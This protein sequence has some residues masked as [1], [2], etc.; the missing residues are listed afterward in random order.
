MAILEP[1]KPPPPDYYAANLE[2]VVAGVAR[3]YNDLLHPDERAHAERILALSPCALRLFA[4]LLSRAGPTIRV[5]RLRYREIDDTNAALDELAAVGLIHRN[6]EVPA[7]RVVAELTIAELNAAFPYV[8]VPRAAH[9][10]E[11]VARI[12]ARYPDREIR[13]RLALVH[14]WVAIARPDIVE[15]LCVLFFGTDERDLTT[16]VLEDLGVWR[17]ET[18]TMDPSARPFATREELDRYRALGALRAAMPS[19]ASWDPAPANR[20][21]DVLWQRDAHRST[22]RRRRRLLDRLGYVA[23]R[24]SDADIALAC[25]KRSGTPFA[26]QRRVRTLLR[27]G[28][29]CGARALLAHIRANPRSRSEREFARRF[30]PTR[31]RLSAHRFAPRIE[32]LTLPSAPP[33]NVER[34]TL[35]ALLERPGLGAHLENR[36]PLALF[37]LA[38]WD[39][40]FAPVPGAFSNA[41]QLGP[42]DLLWS[43]FAAARRAVI[44]ARLDEIR[45]AEALRSRVLG[46]WREKCG[47]S[48]ALVSWELLDPN[49]IGRALDRV[50]V[51]AWRKILAHLANNLAEARTGFPDLVVFYDD[52]AYD[53]VEVKGPGDALRSDQRDWLGLLDS[54]GIAARVLKVSW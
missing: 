36:F 18:Y 38:F 47:V 14:P 15:G 34:A 23:E 21:L 50:P 32:T 52:G 4:R 22:E 29:V 11:L 35:G 24:S 30:E 43:D 31:C 10:A 42:L 20:L 16:F 6:F 5:D 54:V 46:T 51:A 45:S 26:R 2:R 19:R 39:I 28:D 44:D 41:Y 3:Q 25:Y 40:V 8:E 9:K 37:G 7:D 53:V 17:F 49:L 12:V 27:L 1:D 33:H 13:R 48:N